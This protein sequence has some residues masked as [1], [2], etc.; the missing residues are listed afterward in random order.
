LPASS[1]QKASDT[2]PSHCL[3]TG[4]KPPQD[5]GERARE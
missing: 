4:F 1:Y 5:A 2:M 3:E